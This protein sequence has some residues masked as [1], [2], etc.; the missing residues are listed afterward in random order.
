MTAPLEIS[1]NV[2]D[3]DGKTDYD[4]NQQFTFAI[5]LDFD[6]DDSTYDYK[7][8]PLE[9]QL[10]EKDASGYS[11]TVYR[12][13]K[14]GSFTIKKGESI[15]LLNIPVGATYKITEKNVIGYV[16]FKVG[17]Q[18]FDKG[19]FVDTLAEAG[20]ALKFINKVNPT[21]IAISVNKTLDGQAYSG[22]KFGYTLTGLGSM[23]TTKLDTDGKTLSRQTAQQ[24]FPRI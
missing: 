2:V 23:D 8:Y 18:P 21:N 10:K 22:S 9:Y 6:G 16:P 12:T 14:D 3:E 1:K 13:S 4:T 19:T 7:T 20:N 17:D 24:Q 15:K 11:N 5:A